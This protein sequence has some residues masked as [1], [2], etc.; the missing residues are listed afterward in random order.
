[1]KYNLDLVEK[2]LEKIE[3]MADGDAT[4]FVS[5]QD[6]DNQYEEKEISYHIEILLEAKFIIAWS[7]QNGLPVPIKML[8]M[9]GRQFLEGKKNDTLWNKIKPQLKNCGIEELKKAP[10]LFT[11]LL[12]KRIC[13]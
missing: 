4:I 9:E 13:G 3:E 1:M 2:I 11:S 12:I 10:A 8:T 7:K 6:L 5:K